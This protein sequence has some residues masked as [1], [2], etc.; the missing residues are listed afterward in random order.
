MTYDI[1]W[2]IMLY[3]LVNENVYFFLIVSNTLFIKFTKFVSFA[4]NILIT[5]SLFLSN[6]LWKMQIFYI[7][8]LLLVETKQK[9]PEKKTIKT[10]NISIGKFD[11]S[12]NKKW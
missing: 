10:Y 3:F 7:V 11:N 4:Y 9:K 8:D 12:N 2:I 5:D 6:T 1:N